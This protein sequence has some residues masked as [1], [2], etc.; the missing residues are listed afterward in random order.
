MYKYIKMFKR[1]TP[2]LEER[3][4]HMF[5]ITPKSLEFPCE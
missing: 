1:D 4:M 2:K 5:M 3:A